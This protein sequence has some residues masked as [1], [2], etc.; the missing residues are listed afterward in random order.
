MEDKGSTESFRDFT[1]SFFYGSRSDLSFKF[2]SDLTPE[3]AALFIQNLFADIIDTL[4]D[5][6]MEP[7]KKRLLQGQIQGYKAQKNFEYDD[8]PFHRIEKP[9]SALKLSLLTSSGHFLKADDP[10]PFGV[11]NMTQADAERRVMD[12]LK[13]APQLSRI[14]FDSKPSELMVRH[15]GYDIRAAAK[16]PNVAFPYQPMTTLKDQ[17]VFADLTT[18]AYSFVGVCSQKKLMTKILPGW[19]SQF[20][21][22]GV[23]AVVLVPV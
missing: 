22:L 20:L 15:G 12:F 5:R 21:E 19:V 13:G 4:D 3:D 2:L 1:K 9:L 10:K 16:D 11:E 23:D 6:D 8:G 18:C 7:L 17:G 14:P